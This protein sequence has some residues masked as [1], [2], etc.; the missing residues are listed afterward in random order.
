MNSYIESF[1]LLDRPLIVLMNG[2]ISKKIV[3][4][5]ENVAVN[6]DS[7]TSVF[8]VK[9]DQNPV[10]VY[11]FNLENV[12]KLDWEEDEKDL[13]T[14]RSIR[15]LEAS[16]WR[17]EFACTPSASKPYISTHISIRTL[18]GITWSTGNEL[19]SM[20]HSLS[21]GIPSKSSK[22]VFRQSR[23]SRFES[24]RERPS[25]HSCSLLFQIEGSIPD[26]DLA[27]TVSARGDPLQCV[28]I[29]NESGVFSHRDSFNLMN[30]RVIRNQS[31]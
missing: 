2:E 17:M 12:V 4:C 22:L 23:M 14:R 31:C 25:D 20:K 18:E 30:D 29:C 19:R 6:T 15:L 7:F 9:N 26:K 28:T 1:P 13:V 3:L 11:R 24:T 5:H 21:Q 27:M 8:P 10:S 16:S